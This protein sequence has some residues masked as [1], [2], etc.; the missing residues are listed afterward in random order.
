[1]ADGD[2][3]YGDEV[4]YGGDEY[5]Y[6]QDEEQLTQEDYW[7]LITRHFDQ[8]GLVRQQIDSFN[9]FIENTLQE[10][11][12]ENTNIVMEKTFQGN[13]GQDMIKRYHIGFGQ[14]F[15]SPPL[16]TEADG[17]VHTLYPQEA[18]LRSMTYA[19]TLM[20]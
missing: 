20:V 4:A 17:V 13:Q 11:V 18:R 8:Y 15:I 16:V 14:V 7:T 10:I 3:Y 5:D 1:M 2:F 19:S 12:D 9:D 6:E